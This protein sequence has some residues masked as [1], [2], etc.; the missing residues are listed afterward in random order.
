M[1]RPLPTARCAFL[2]LIP[3]DIESVTILKDAAAAAVYGARAAN[4][5]VLVQTKRAKGD[6]KVQVNYRG[7]YNVEQSTRNPEFLNAYDFALLR[8]RAV[9]NTPGTTITKYT[10]RA[11]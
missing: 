9:D 8:N 5:V 1:V 10:D 2:T 7:Q 3:D 6:Q 11:A 4:G